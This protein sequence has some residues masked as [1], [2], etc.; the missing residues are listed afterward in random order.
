MVRSSK[1][2]ARMDT[3]NADNVKSVVLPLDGQG[4]NKPCLKTECAK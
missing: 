4:N 3:D 2:Q 1:R